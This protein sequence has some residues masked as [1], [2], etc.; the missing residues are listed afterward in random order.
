[1]LIERT[2][3]T[4]TS[5]PKKIL[6]YENNFLTFNLSYDDYTC[7][8]INNSTTSKLLF[9]HNCQFILK[10]NEQSCLKVT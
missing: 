8:F 5:K 1:M 7:C 4:T 3:Q 10:N 9:M 2:A 6:S